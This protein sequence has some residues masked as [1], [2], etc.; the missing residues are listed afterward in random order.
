MI[1]LYILC[2]WC[3]REIHELAQRDMYAE[4]RFFCNRCDC[5]IV[6]VNMSKFEMQGR[7]KVPR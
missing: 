7:G 6:R 2:P 5:V 4:M 1:R 3:G